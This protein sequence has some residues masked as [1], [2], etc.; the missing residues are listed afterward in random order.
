[1]SQRNKNIL[2]ILFLLIIITTGITITYFLIRNKNIKVPIEE[3]KTEEIIPIDDKKYF[4]E[5]SKSNVIN[6]HKRYKENAIKI[7][8][9][10]G[11]LKISGLKDK[12]TIEKINKKLSKVEPRECYN[13]GEDCNIS[14]NF[15]NVL[16]IDGEK[17]KLNIDL[18]TGNEITFEELFNKDTDI[19]RIIRKSGIARCSSADY[20]D[21]VISETVDSIKSGKFIFNIAV[22]AIYVDFSD[23]SNI[24]IYFNE[25]LDDLTIYD[26]FE[27]EESI[28][29]EDNLKTS[30]PIE[31]NYLI[32]NPTFIKNSFITINDSFKEYHSEIIPEL[33][34]RYN[35]SSKDYTYS[36]IYFDEKKTDLGYTIIQT[37][38]FKSQSSKND[39]DKHIMGYPIP[40]A[41]TDERFY[42]TNMILKDGEITFLEN[43]I[44]KYIED[45]SSRLYNITYEKSE[46]DIGFSSDGCD[47]YIEESEIK[48]C[49]KRLSKENLGN[50]VGAAIDFDNELLYVYYDEVTNESPVIWIDHAFPLSEFTLK[51]M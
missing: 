8:K 31:W 15:S 22:D 36:S 30:T 24:W 17:G 28:Y 26:R 40:P 12:K 34:K 42:V 45:F 41:P 23:G 47:Y 46:E 6:I 18:T 14:F 16:S 1:M 4:K 29:E 37:R 50:V 21:N 2:F 10:N 44:N 20:C 39:F 13:G 43:N 19:L 32:N 48:A 3:E 5:V 51:E 11:K 7:N 38:I 33:D 49:K 27:T 25:V 9:E 35:L